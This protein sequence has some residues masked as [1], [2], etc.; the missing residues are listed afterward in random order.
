MSTFD[1]CKKIVPNPDD[2]RI[3]IRFNN[4]LE[5]E[6]KVYLKSE[7]NPVPIS[8]NYK[9]KIGIN[10]KLQKSFNIV[11]SMTLHQL[12]RNNYSKHCINKMFVNGEEL[13][14]ENLQNETRLNL[15][16]IALDHKF[17]VKIK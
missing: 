5:E 17:D 9:N 11:K 3:F 6:G 2:Y 12:F 14:E 7:F 15:C 4:I 8:F 1:K 13:R 16:V 10:Q